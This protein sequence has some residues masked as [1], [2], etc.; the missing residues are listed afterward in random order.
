LPLPHKWAFVVILATE[1]TLMSTAHQILGVKP[2]AT[3][4]EIKKAFRKK[5]HRLHPDVNKAPDAEERWLELYEAYELLLRH[6]DRKKRV[7]HKSKSSRAA[8]H[9]PPPTKQEER[10][11]AR[12]RA[13]A[14]ARAHARMKFEAY[15][16]TA[17]YRNE[18]ALEVIGDN[19]MFYSAVSVIVYL[20]YQATALGYEFLFIASIFIGLAAT[21]LWLRAASP[22]SNIRLSLLFNA[23][24]KIVQSRVFSLLALAGCNVLLYFLYAFN[25]FCNLKIS[26]GLLL[27]AGV[28]GYVLV[29]QNLLF[30]HNAYSR[31]IAAYVLFPLVINLFFALNYLFASAPRTQ[32]YT[33]ESQM[34]RIT[35]RGGSSY[36]RSR[37]IAV[38]ELMDYQGVRFFWS[39]EDKRSVSKVEYVLADGLFGLKVVK[40][41]KLLPPY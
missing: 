27:G 26:G 34:V 28:L 24:Y 12:E 21:P 33:Y 8:T 19:F 13:R 17:Y 41:K 39:S 7:R 18:L 5:A 29:K 3:T 6:K 23:V 22:T 25:T 40:Q 35:S 14:R 4:A 32:Q 9:T 11:K 30:P 38:E 20:L 10:E 2:S 36:E 15:K 16:K 1:I 31:S 37:F